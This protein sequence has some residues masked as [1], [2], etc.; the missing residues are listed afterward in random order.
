M[1]NKGANIEAKT[2]GGDTPLIKAALLKN[3]ECYDYLISVG[4]NK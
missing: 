4:A 2:I 1:I 3:H